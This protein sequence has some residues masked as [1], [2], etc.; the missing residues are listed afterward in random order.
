[1]D[2]AL[3]VPFTVMSVV[4]RDLLYTVGVYECKKPTSFTSEGDFVRCFFSML[5]VHP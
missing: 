5:V 3:L 4:P 2:E 1:M